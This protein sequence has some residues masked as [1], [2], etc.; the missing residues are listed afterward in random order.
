MTASTPASPFGP[1]TLDQ[2]GTVSGGRHCGARKHSHK[3]GHGAHQRSAPGGGQAA[4]SLDMTSAA[5]AGDGT[6]A[7]GDDPG[8]TPPAATP[9][10]TGLAGALGGATGARAK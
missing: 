8:G 7:L 4:T 10:G 3:A 6:G 2:L 9:A 1:L 5:S